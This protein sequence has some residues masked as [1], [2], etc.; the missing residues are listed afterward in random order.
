M[1]IIDDKTLEN[2][3]QKAKKS[4]RKRINFNY[5]SGESDLLQRLLNALEPSTYIRP[6]KHDNPDKREVFIILKGSIAAVIFDDNGK[7]TTYIVM[8]RENGIYAVEI[9]PKTWHTLFSLE[10][11]SVMYEVKDGPYNANTDKQFADWAP[12]EGSDKADGY[13]EE[14]KKIVGDKNTYHIGTWNT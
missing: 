14:L 8:N 6:H 13:L 5:H 12:E 11:N 7:I 4:N 9:P 10:E 3:S 2:L 1:K